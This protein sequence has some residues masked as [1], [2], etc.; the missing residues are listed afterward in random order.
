MLMTARTQAQNAADAGALSGA[1]A[2][3]FNSYTDRTPTG[4]AVR[5]AMSAARGNQVMGQAPNVT[6]DDVTFPPNG[7]ANNRVHVQVYRTAARGNPLSMLMGPMFGVNLASV[8]ASATAETASAT[9]ATC[10]LPFAIPDKWIEGNSPPWDESDIYT[11]APDVYRGPY[12]S[13]PTGYRP[14]NDAG[15]ILT[16][17]AANGNNIAPSLF[18]ALALPGNTG[19]S[20]FEWAIPN[21]NPATI[22]L[23]DRMIQEPGNQVGPASHGFLE[24]IAKDPGAYWDGR[25]V[26]STQNP[27]PR[28]KLVPLF[29]PEFWWQGKQNGR[30]ADFKATNFLGFFVETVQ[31]GNIKGR[32]VPATAALDSTVQPPTSSFAQVIRLVE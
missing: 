17:K 13:N 10:V 14:W 32:I 24:L 4:P 25:K 26:V 22:H 5:G 16:L 11:G 9:A 3:V 18:F 20:D 2:L 28:V 30:Y 1:T 19:S 6:P 31:G 12:T 7:G 21:C 15:S 8:T 29:D 23:N 27:S